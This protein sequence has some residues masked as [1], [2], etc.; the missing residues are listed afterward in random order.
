M[1]ALYDTRTLEFMD[2]YRFPVPFCIRIYHLHLPR[3]RDGHLNALINISIGMTCQSDR[4]LPGLHIRL[5]PF[6]NDR[7]AEHGAVQ[8]SADRTVGALPHLLQPIF[9]H[10]RRI[11]S[12]GGAFHR[13]AVFLGGFRRV[14]RHLVVG[15]VAVLKSQIIVLC[16]QI[17]KR[18]QKLLFDHL[19]E[20]PGHLVA[21]HF[22]QRRR[23][24]DLF[25]LSVLLTLLFG[26]TIKYC[27]V[28]TSG[29]FLSP[30]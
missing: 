5:N 28:R 19:P 22:Y 23:H 17:H 27:P 13:H 7:S 21:V 30:G 14:C 18:K 8:D 29:Y 25:H 26:L 16:L 11:G 20:N 12:N 9:L 2:S 15:A 6:Y 4:L 1:H 10:S 3:S 24:L